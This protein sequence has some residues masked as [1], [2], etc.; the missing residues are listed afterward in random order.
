MALKS[1]IMNKSLFG[2]LVFSLFVNPAFSQIIEKDG[3]MSDGVQNALT[4]DLTGSQKLVESQWKDFSKKFGKLA[5]DKKTKEYILHEVLIPS[6][7]TE[8]PVTVIT[9]FEE[10]DNLTRAYF[11]FKRDEKYLNSI[12]NEAE[13]AGADVFLTN[14]SV[15]VKKEFVGKELD[16]EEKNLRKL[17]K[18]LDKLKD[19]NDDLHRDIEK[20]ED[21][22]RKAKIDI[23]RNLEEQE[24]AKKE[25]ETQREK[26]K[27]V[28]QKMNAIGKN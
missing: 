22:I 5:R 21:T 27:L 2:I 1:T 7:D 3:S 28:S 9:K 20:A 18:A 4:M 14:F 11:W 12:D 26:L 19:K 17:E 15:Q 13:I 8:Y 25:I 23:E 6:I 24:R 16:E 10:F